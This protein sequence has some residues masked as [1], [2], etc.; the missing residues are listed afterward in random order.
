MFDQYRVNYPG[1][2]RHRTTRATSAQVRRHRAA[3]TASPRARSSTGSR[4]LLP[5][6]L[7]LGLRRGRGRL[8][9]AARLREQRRHTRRL[10]Q[11]R[12]DRD[13][14]ARPPL[15]RS[16]DR[17]VVLY[18]PGSLLS[19]QIDT[20]APA[21]WENERRQP[22]LVRRRPGLPGPDPSKYG[23]EVVGKYPTPESNCGAAGSSVANTSTRGP[24]RRVQG[25]EG[26]RRERSA[27]RPG[28]APGIARSRRWCSTPS[29]YGRRRS[30]D[31]RSVRPSRLAD[32]P[33][34]GSSGASPGGS[35][36]LPRESTNDRITG[37]RHRVARRPKILR[38]AGGA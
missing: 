35:V 37:H 34:R 26:I 1:H 27:A 11:R 23:A 30:F 22:G 3:R 13:E 16:C 8:E 6:R 19:Q 14:P 29:T 18:S 28:T 31:G 5:G 33:S 12:R 2:S 36:P 4:G 9:Q 17:L 21:A 38:R 15:E 10:R 24:Q 32:H 7:E 20:E 25:R